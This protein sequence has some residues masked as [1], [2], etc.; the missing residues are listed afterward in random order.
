MGV[1]SA[2]VL[3]AVIWAMIFMIALPI[4]VKTQ[5]DLGEIVEGTHAGAPEQHHLKKKAW[6]TTGITLVLWAFTVW[7]ILSGIVTVA[8]IEHWLHGDLTPIGGTDG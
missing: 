8:D 6:W 2:F 4:R 3:F 5:G 1:T 7:F